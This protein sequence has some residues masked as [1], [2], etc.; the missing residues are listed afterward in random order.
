[1]AVATAELVPIIVLE[2]INPS[3]HCRARPFI[4]SGDDFHISG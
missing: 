3:L 2:R 1:L 4:R